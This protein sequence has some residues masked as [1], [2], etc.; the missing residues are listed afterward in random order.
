MWTEEQCLLGSFL[1]IIIF[2]EVRKMDA[3]F[4]VLPERSE[5]IYITRRTIPSKAFGGKSLGGDE[6]SEREQI[7]TT[8]DWLDAQAGGRENICSWLFSG[9][10]SPESRSCCPR[11]T[12]LND[13]QW[14]EEKTYITDMDSSYGGLCLWTARFYNI[15]PLRCVDYSA[16]RPYGLIFWSV[17]RIDALG[18]RHE[19]PPY[20]VC[21]VICSCRKGLG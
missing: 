12:T 10:V 2:Y 6:Y 7:A 19:G 16:F 21:T 9:P 4:S 8:L 20:V 14:A 3:D 15:S 17:I 11:Y 1:C 5:T 13:K 18:F